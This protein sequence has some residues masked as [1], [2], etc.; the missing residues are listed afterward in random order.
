MVKEGPFI[1]ASNLRWAIISLILMNTVVQNESE[2][3][4]NF[5]NYFLSNLRFTHHFRQTPWNFHEMDC[6]EPDLPMVDICKH[7]PNCRLK[8]NVFCNDIRS[9]RFFL[10]AFS[11]MRH[12]KHCLA[13]AFT[14]REMTDFQGIAW[15]KVSRRKKVPWIRYLSPTLQGHNP[16]DTLTLDHFGYCAKDDAKRCQTSDPSID[17]KAWPPTYFRNTGVVNFHLI[18]GVLSEKSAM[19]IFIHELGHSL[20]AKHDDE[21]E[22][23]VNMT[24]EDFLMTGDAKVILI[25]NSLYDRLLMLC[26]YVELKMNFL[27][28]ECSFRGAVFKFFYNLL[29]KKLMARGLFLGPLLS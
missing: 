20:G 2:C 13:F 25:A 19:H 26:N 7:K 3:D 5:T 24:D 16:N 28:N 12:D 4:Q 10:H 23:C 27:V 6:T 21:S 18:R 1:R 9:M 14:Y 8:G 15:I 22:E 29:R 11:A 17:A